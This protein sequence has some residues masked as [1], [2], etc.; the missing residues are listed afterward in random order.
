MINVYVSIYMVAQMVKNVPAVQKTLVW[1][2]GQEDMTE[3]KV[4][5]HSS[6]LDWRIP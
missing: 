2:L 3:E 4:V 5:T 1:S 6:I